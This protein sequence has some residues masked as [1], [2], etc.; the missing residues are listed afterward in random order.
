M[1]NSGKVLKNKQMNIE[2][3]ILDIHPYG[4]TKPNT[5][6][7]RW[8]TYVK[9]GNEKRKIVRAPSYDGLME[10]LFDFYYGNTK[11][12]TLTMQALFD[13]WLP[14]KECITDSPNT[15]RRH[16]QHWKKYFSSWA[17]NK[18]TK[19]DKL[20][21]QKQCNLLV[22]EYNLSSKEW[23]N[24][25]TI[26]TGM[27]LYAFEKGYIKLNPMTDVK[28]TVKYR[29]VNKKTGETETFQTNE[30]LILLQYFDSQYAIT[31]D[32][33]YLALKLDFYLGLRVGELSALRWQ[34]IIGL[35]NLHICREEIKKS[36]RTQD[37]WKDVYEVT[38]H[39]KT[40]TDRIIPLVP[41]AVRL[42]NDLR[43]QTACKASD[44][45]FIFTRDGER[46]TSRQITYALEKACETN[47]LPVKRTHKIR[48]TVASN[49]NSGGVPTDAIREI[50]GH[51][52]LETTM[53]YIYNPL[54]EKE[55]Y[56]LISKAL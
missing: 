7:G 13:E 4:I 56:Q 54:S 39:T 9:R 46:I 53:G 44:T 48:K 5:E 19:Y 11:R 27:F 43:F 24:I 25:K 17:D 51:S 6:K 35:K 36:V 28:I 2:Q 1:V 14:Y 16:E 22:K 52:N 12:Q 47:N 10:K 23:Q 30:K 18:I 40:H 41:G 38:D 21:L 55:T 34:D 49:L 33:V 50:L 3:R 31:N 29:Q 42:L 26:L 15:I 45:D 37:G 8:Q 32:S 20:E